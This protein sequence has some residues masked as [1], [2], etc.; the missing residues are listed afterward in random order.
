MNVKQ[1]KI[2]KNNTNKS[3]ISGLENKTNFV[4]EGENYFFFVKC[5][6]EKK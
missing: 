4:E 3:I 2:K 1:K 5:K 6:I